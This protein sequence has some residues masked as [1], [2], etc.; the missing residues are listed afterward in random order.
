MHNIQL[1]TRDELPYAMRPVLYIGI[2]ESLYLGKLLDFRS[3][4][5]LLD[6]R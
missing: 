6:H 1:C 2:C 3:R 5:R 4:V